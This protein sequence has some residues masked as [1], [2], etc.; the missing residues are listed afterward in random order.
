M[1]YMNARFDV[2]V[3]YYQT[4]ATMAIMSTSLYN[5]YMHVQFCHMTM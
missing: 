3:L 5:R 4:L 1:H 2:Y